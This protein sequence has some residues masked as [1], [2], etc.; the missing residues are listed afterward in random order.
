MAGGL[1]GH[2]LQAVGD[3]QAL[4]VDQ[5]DLVVLPAE[6]GVGPGI[7]R[8]DMAAHEEA[9]ASGFDFLD[10][11]PIL[12]IDDRNDAAADVGRGENPAAVALPVDART[13]V[14]HAR[15]GDFGDLFSIVEIDDFAAFGLP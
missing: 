12:Q 14:R 8:I 1:A 11:L 2:G 5:Q 13:Q 15:Q 3:F 9:G 4:L 7:G 10:R 6:E